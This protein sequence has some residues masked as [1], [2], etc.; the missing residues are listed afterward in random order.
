M[1]C[2]VSLF[3]ENSSS[4]SNFS[5]EKW[6]TGF[7]AK[8]SG[9]LKYPWGAKNLWFV[10]FL[11]S[12][13]VFEFCLSEDF[14][15][16]ILEFL[17]IGIFFIHEICPMSDFAWK[18]ELTWCWLRN[19]SQFYNWGEKSSNMWTLKRWKLVVLK[20][21]SS[22]SFEVSFG[23]WRALLRTTRSPMNWNCLLNLKN[24]GILIVNC[25]WWSINRFEADMRNISLNKRMCVKKLSSNESQDFLQ[26]VDSPYHKEA[27]MNIFILFKRPFLG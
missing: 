22:Q 8:F 17:S 2:N 10:E 14:D 12:E 26:I 4:T 13:K 18:D 7:C 6:V 15:D 5:E 21:V 16:F 24:L 9:L 20:N 25:R 27:E 23:A 1:T 19:Q 11:V 3:A